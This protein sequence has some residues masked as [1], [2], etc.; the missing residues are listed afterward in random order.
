MTWTKPR[1]SM[2]LTWKKGSGKRPPP[3]YQRKRDRWASFLRPPFVEEMV[4]N[5][6][7]FTEYLTIFFVTLPPSSIHAGDAVRTEAELGDGAPRL[8]RTLAGHGYGAQASKEGTSGGT[9]ETVG[10]RYRHP[11]KTQRHLR[12]IMRATAVNFSHLSAARCLPST[13]NNDRAFHKKLNARAAA[14]RPYC[15][16]ISPHHSPTLPPNWHFCTFSIS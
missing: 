3:S 7:L 6:W 10:E 11:R 16:L 12:G 15:Y 1:R 8:P 14:I 4:V 5:R 13:K 9:H 2:M